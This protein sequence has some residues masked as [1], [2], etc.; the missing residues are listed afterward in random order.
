[1]ESCSNQKKVLNKSPFALMTAWH[2]LFLYILKYSPV[3][4]DCNHT[5]KHYA[6]TTMLEH[7]E[8]GTQ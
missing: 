8:S 3:L 4:N 6:A 1:M 5:H 7:M 2:S